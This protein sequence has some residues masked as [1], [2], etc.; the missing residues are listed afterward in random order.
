MGIMPSAARPAANVTACYTMNKDHMS[1]KPRL[2][3]LKQS[4]LATASCAHSRGV[5]PDKHMELEQ[6][7]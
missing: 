2:L 7:D 1:A 3:L 5:E 6:G 4:S